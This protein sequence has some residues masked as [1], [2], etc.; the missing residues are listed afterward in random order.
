MEPYALRVEVLTVAW[1][2]MEKEESV[3]TVQSVAERAR[4]HVRHVLAVG[5]HEE[6][7]TS[8]RFICSHLIFRT[9]KDA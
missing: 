3:K 7:G 9:E 8:Y 1:N 4:R 6:R 5:K 2:A